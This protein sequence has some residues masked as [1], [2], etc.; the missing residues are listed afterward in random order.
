MFPPDFAKDFVL[1][2]RP[3]VLQT[4]AISILGTIIGVAIGGVLAIPATSS[5]VLAQPD[6]P[7]LQSVSKRGL[8]WSIFWAARL[9]LN[10]L[11]SIPDLVW[12]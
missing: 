10:V 3:L 5:L 1:G 11:R 9:A 12:V 7:G 4:L 8:R 6:S 2:L